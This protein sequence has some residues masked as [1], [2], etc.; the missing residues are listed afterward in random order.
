MPVQIRSDEIFPFIKVI[1]NFN[2][3]DDDELCMYDLWDRFFRMLF[4]KLAQ[5]KMQILFLVC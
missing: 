4:S 2:E 3:I 1:K 5:N